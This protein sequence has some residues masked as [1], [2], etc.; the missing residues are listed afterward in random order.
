ML[1]KV[2]LQLG[3]SLQL[4]VL[5]DGLEAASPEKELRISKEAESWWS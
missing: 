3:V 5:A 4:G 1:S 2:H